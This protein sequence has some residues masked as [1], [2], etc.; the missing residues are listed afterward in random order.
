MALELRRSSKWWYATFVVNGKKTVVNLGVPIT[1][2]RPRKRTMIGDDEF[3]RSRGR[4]MEA[5][6]KQLRKLEE[7]RTGEKTLA[8]LAELKTGR[9]VTFPRLGD[10]ARHWDAIPRRAGRRSC[11]IATWSI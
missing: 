8:K 10:L 4:A 3:E 9:E 1:G 5:H 6:D 11:G 2:K 7:D